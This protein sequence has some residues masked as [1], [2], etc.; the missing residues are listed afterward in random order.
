MALK[1]RFNRIIVI[2]VALVT[3]V[4]CFAPLTSARAEADGEPIGM[5]VCTAR[6][7]LSLRIGPSETYK[8]MSEL[9]AGTFVEVYAQSGKWYQIEYNGALLWGSTSCLS[10]APMPTVADA[11]LTADTGQTERSYTIYYQGDP[12]WRFSTD[13]RK[14]ACLM[15]AYSITVNNM[16]IPATPR[17]IYESNKRRTT[18]NI[19]NLEANFGVAPVCALPENSKYLRGFNGLSTYVKSA[20]RNAVDAIKQALDLHPE[21]VICYFKRGEEAHAIVACKYDGDTIYYSDPG[22][23]RGTL[24][25]FGNTWVVYGHH[26]GYS[27]LAEIIALDTVDEIAAAAAAL[28]IATPAESLV[29]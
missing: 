13:V 11:A 6:S 26:M 4:L 29:A 23:K 8:S 15:T 27:N 24:L 20:G 21:G 5:A 1:K 16:G 17:F 2:F 9:P 18:M 10:F 7:S 19:A 22:R 25:T 14:V 12:Q 28:P 3:I